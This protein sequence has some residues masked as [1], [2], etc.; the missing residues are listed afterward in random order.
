MIGVIPPVICLYIGNDRYRDLKNK[1]EQSGIESYKFSKKTFFAIKQDMKKGEKISEEDLVE[2]KL[3][4]D[5]SVEEIL[6]ENIIGRELKIDVSKGVL[7]NSDMLIEDEKVADDLRLHMFSNIELHSQ[8]VEGSMIDIRI[9]FPN[10]ED[11]ILASRKRIEGRLEEKILIYVNEEEILK[12][13]SADIDKSMY[14]GAKI[15]AILY[16][17]DYQESATSNYPA[18]LSVIELGNWDPNLVNKVFT[19]DMVNKR[20]VL[21]EHLSQIST[22][23]EEK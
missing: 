23:Q 17:K 12:I 10:G 1:Y 13:S 11:Y 19:E 2:V 9:S 20:M 7:V 14:S 15:Y 18:N 5:E 8:I 16:V 22:K 3:M 4:T 6:K 21:E